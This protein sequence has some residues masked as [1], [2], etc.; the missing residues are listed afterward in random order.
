MEN[1]APAWFLRQLQAEITRGEPVPGDVWPW[2]LSFA[3]ATDTTGLMAFALQNGGSSPPRE[4]QEE[5]ARLFQAE[6]RRGA[7]FF[8][9][10][11]RI[12]DALAGDGVEAVFLKGLPLARTVYEHPACRSSRDLDLLVGPAQLE[13]TLARLTGLGYA[14]VDPPAVQEAH[15]RHHFHLA[16]G[17]S[18]RPRLEVHWGLT[19]PDDPYRLEAEVVAA[20]AAP[21]EAV[22]GLRC[23]HPDAQVLHAAVSLLRCGF[24]QL[25]RIIDLD[26]L[27]RSGAGPIRWPRII[28]L[29]RE[30]GLEPA[31]RLLLE[32]SE[33]FFGT[34]LEEPLSLAA[35]LGRRRRRL[36]DLGVERFPLALPPSAWGPA[37]HLV[38]FW[39]AEHPF[40]VARQFFGR[41]RF[42]RA[43]VAAFG[44]GRRV[45]AQAAVKRA[46]I[47]AYLA[48]WQCAL[49][50]RPHAQPHLLPVTDAPPSSAPPAGGR[51]GSPEQVP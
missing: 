8:V 14:F 16:M 35:P 48:A 18:G 10:A 46:L 15:R 29:A 49:Y 2:L 39:L 28:A 17:G 13:R 24:T 12:H 20:D 7:Y 11:Q 4:I 22:G 43:R 21:Q 3:S 1:H 47:G 40:Q 27:V 31:L 36:D 51:G 34:P 33:L 23:P 5:F 32:L 42:E 45:R 41:P 38:R 44:I 50:F 26:R 6:Q 25:K 19:R 9:E 37:R 30:R